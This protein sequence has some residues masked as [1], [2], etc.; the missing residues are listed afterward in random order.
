MK[1]ARNHFDKKANKHQHKHK[2]TYTYALQRPARTVL[3][4]RMASSSGSMDGHAGVGVQL[5]RSPEGEF[6]ISHI[7]ADSPVAI[8]K[9]CMTFD[10]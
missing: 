6:T 10:L 2:H 1:K 3:V 8:E 9:V 7:M 5:H 4:Q